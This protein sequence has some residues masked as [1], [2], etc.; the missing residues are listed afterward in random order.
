MGSAGAVR[1]GRVFVEIGAD[2]KGFFS[3]LQAV[4]A[5]IATVGDT[6]K[7][8]GSRLAGVG[9]VIAGP[10]TAVGAIMAA[11]TVEV[12]Q[13]QNALADLGAEIGK[14]VLPAFTGFARLVTGAAQ[15]VTRFVRENPQLVRSIAAVG[16]TLTGAGL[17]M[18]AFG[19]TLKGLSGLIDAAAGPM[20]KVSA[21]VG[22]MGG[23]LAR[24]V[25]SG[26]FVALAA[27]IGVAALA[28]RAA[29]ADFAKLGGQIVKGVR[30]PIGRAVGLLG[31]LKDTAETT[32][33]GM[34]KAIAG[35]D[36]EKAVD[37]MWAGINAAW[38]R[39]EQAM[40]G[41]LDPW[42]EQVQNAFGDLGTWLAATW[43]KTW[44]G[45][46][47]S[48]W[49]QTLLGALDNWINMFNASFDWLVANIEKAWKRVQGF[50]DK[51][52][53]VQAEIAAIDARTAANAA[54]RERLRP[55]I[56]GRKAMDDAEKERLRK[57]TE[58]RIQAMWDQ[59]KADRQARSDR[60]AALVAERE[61]RVKDLQKEL[62]DMVAKVPEP[63]PIVA[64]QAARTEVAGTF[65]ANVENV[66]GGVSVAKLQLDELRGMRKDLQRVMN[67][68]G[69]VP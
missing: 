13:A 43:E 67:I 17:A 30:E 24:L 2:T 1:Q 44:L 47:T 29:G 7:N 23:V 5:R 36:L 57:E 54:E 33:D 53:N 52:M 63:P 55:G 35:G 28:A 12:R 68:G 11:Q 46:S 42:T 66:I 37:I 62:K 31:E 14:A 4:N 9:A 48:S 20:M 61:Q 40:L 58:M 45:I 69:I 21:A 34:F 49:G 26:P 18:M 25:T 59:N 56:A 32:V 19:A 39:G 51:G 38:A 3:A 8:V 60:T 6:L 41:S 10:I 50:F 15:A 64:P 27:V 22:Q 65:A 16:W